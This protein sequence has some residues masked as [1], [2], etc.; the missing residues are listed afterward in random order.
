ME[1]AIFTSG[2][3]E[4]IDSTQSPRA[5]MLEFCDTVLSF[6]PREIHKIKKRVAKFQKVKDLW[7]AKKDE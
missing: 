3:H 1:S 2:K 6:Y 4:E 5:W 7:V